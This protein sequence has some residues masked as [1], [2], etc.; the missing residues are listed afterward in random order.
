MNNCLKI[1]HLEDDPLD[2]EMIKER[3]LAEDLICEIVRVETEEKFIAALEQ[4]SFD[5]ILADF[6]L[7]TFDGMSALQFVKEKYPEIPFI[8]ISGTLGEELAIESLKKGATD[9]VIKQRLSRLAPSVI[10]ALKEVEERNERRKAEA[11]LVRLASVVEQ[12]GESIVIVNLGG[13]IEYVNPN[14]EKLTGY[15]SAEVIGENPKILKSGEQSK[16]FYQELWDTITSGKTWFGIFQNKRKDGT[17][18]YEDAVIF[19]I[20]DQNG[21]IINYAAVKRDITSEKLLEEQLVQSQKLE[22]IGQLAGGIAHDFNNILTAI[23]G[24]SEIAMMNLNPEQQVYKDIKAIMKAGQ[25]ASNLTRQLLAFS[26]KQLIQPKIIDIN[27][28]II[29]LDKMLNRL[30]GEDIKLSVYLPEK[31]G[32]INADPGQIEQ[33]L[34]NLIINARDAVNH[35]TIPSARKT[36][37]IETKDVVVDD[38]FLFNK[39]ETP[40]GPYVLISV[41]DTGIGM[42]DETRRKIFEPFFTTKKDGK[43]TGLGLA[44]VYGIVKQNKASISVESKVDAGTTFHIYWPCAESSELSQEMVDS[45]GEIVGGDETILFVE[46]DR[47]VRSFSSKA[48]K[49]LGYNVVVA[50]NG[51][52]ALKIYKRKKL[53]FD[54]LITDVIMPDMGGKELAEK[55]GEEIDDLK[56]LFASGYTDDHITDS[57]VL[58]QD[59]N[60]IQKPY[61]IQALAKKIREVLRS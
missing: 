53:D 19:P 8:L 6:S 27:R 56:V 32:R 57:G 15:T 33:I 23:L 44:T 7:P 35:P 26:R 24:Y 18:F 37:V 34:I 9:Y 49:T 52:A 43:G 36:I 13:N 39:Q 42:D 31:I 40:N 10:R 50:R 4:H 25:K 5:L 61:R 17:M 47:G 54:L 38:S 55:L 30:I 3:L 11:Q 58:Q 46:D 41:K 45:E 28:L 16:K 29:D 14:F 48:L 1:L 20:K 22:G 12:A 59:I 21:V 60:F 51:V 2:S